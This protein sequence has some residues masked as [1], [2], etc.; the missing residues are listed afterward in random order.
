MVGLCVFAADQPYALAHLGGNSDS[1]A[2]DRDMLRGQLRTTPMTQYDV[3]EISM[4]T[5]AVV[6]EYVTRTGTVFA[7]TWQGPTPPNL[8]QLFG[9][10]FTRFSS[11]AVASAQAHSGTHRQ[12]SINQGDFIVQNAGHMRAFVGRAYLPALMPAGVSISDLP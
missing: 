11:A 2:T 1:V 8:R 7:I 4:G 6:R 3:H 12:L 10:Y 5:S 9:D